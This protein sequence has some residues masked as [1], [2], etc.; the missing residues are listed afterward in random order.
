MTTLSTKIDASEAIALVDQVKDNTKSFRDTLEDVGDFL[1]EEFGKNYDS[2]GAL[3]GGWAPLSPR[4]AAW[5]LSRGFPTPTLVET[6]GLRSAVESLNKRAGDQRAVY[7][8]DSDIAPFHQYGTRHMPARPISF[9]PAGFAE[10][11]ARRIADDI[12][13]SQSAVK[14][15]AFFR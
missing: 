8:V 3:V 7:E 12:I 9:V 4:T 15:G 10:L 6:G 2:S 13:P 1:E 5:K 11:V 14:S